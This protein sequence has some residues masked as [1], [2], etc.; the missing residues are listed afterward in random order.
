MAILKKFLFCLDLRVGGIIAAW[1]GVLASP[2]IAVAMVFFVHEVAPRPAPD[3]HRA[4]WYTLNSVVVCAV[5]L[6]VFNSFFS[7]ELLTGIRCVSLNIELGSQIDMQLKIL[8]NNASLM[9]SYLVVQFM[10]LVFPLLSIAV[11]PNEWFIFGVV[12]IE[13]VLIY[14]L[15]CVYSLF[16]RT[17]E[18]SAELERSENL[19]ALQDFKAPDNIEARTKIISINSF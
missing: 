11:L 10:L 12:V 16:I 7:Y 13:V 17:R 8:Q 19:E 3:I 6:L 15:L 14:K 5:T 1:W 4:F 9:T 2:I 18:S